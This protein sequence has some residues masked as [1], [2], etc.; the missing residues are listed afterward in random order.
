MQ[1]KSSSTKR[2]PNVIKLHQG[3]ATPIKMWAAATAKQQQAFKGSGFRSACDK[4]EKHWK[5]P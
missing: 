1:C 4:K 2:Q 5:L 3:Y